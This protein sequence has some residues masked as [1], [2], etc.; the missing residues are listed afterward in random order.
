MRYQFNAIGFDDRVHAGEL[1]IKV[2]S[3]DPPGPDVE[4]LQMFDSQGIQYVDKA[5]GE[6]LA[7]CHRYIVARGPMA[8]ELGGSGRPDPKWLL[9]GDEEWNTAHEDDEA[10]DD[11]ATWRPRALA[12]R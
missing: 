10:C 11:C 8:G 6:A 1:A 9:V 5:S 12:V 7:E 4:E 3:S 2:L